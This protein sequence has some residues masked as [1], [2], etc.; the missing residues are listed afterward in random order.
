MLFELNHGDFAVF[1]GVQAVRMGRGILGSLYKV[2]F[3]AM[4]AHL[5]SYHGLNFE[6]HTV[7]AFFTVTVAGA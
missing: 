6:L 1:L 4:A 3:P 2:L 7:A 5:R